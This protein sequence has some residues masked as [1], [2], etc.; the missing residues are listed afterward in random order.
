MK[1]DDPSTFILDVFSNMRYNSAGEDDS[2][3]G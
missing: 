1:V 2:T 3:K